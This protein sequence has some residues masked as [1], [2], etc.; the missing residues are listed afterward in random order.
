MNR[1][2]V[3]LLLNFLPKDDAKPWSL[4]IRCLLQWYITS[5]L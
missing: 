5:I 4:L 3:I 2:N 1:W